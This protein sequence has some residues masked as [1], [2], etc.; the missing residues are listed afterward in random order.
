LTSGL[1]RTA[2]EGLDLIAQVVQVAR[3]TNVQIMAGSGVTPSTA[4]PVVTRTGVSF[5]H[6]SCR[7]PPSNSC[8]SSARLD[9]PPHRETDPMLVAQLRET[10]DALAGIKPVGVGA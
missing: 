2:L 3:N 9:M 6:A 4:E 7:R 5:V 8:E 10:L 1:Q